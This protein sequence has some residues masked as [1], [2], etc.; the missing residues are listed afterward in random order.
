MRIVFF[1]KTGSHIAL[2]LAAFMTL[3]ALI[4][5]APSRLLRNSHSQITGTIRDASHAIVVG[6]KVTLRNTDT[7]IAKVATSNKDG[8]YLFTLVPIGTYEL[9]VE[10]TGF[11]KY[12]RKGI[13]LVINQNAKQDV[14]LKLGTTSQIVEVQGMSH[15]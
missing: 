10:Q 15:R 11:S 9:S 13:T 3:T 7:N 6:A 2:P 8:D 12:I 1:R 5:P 14:E 4:L